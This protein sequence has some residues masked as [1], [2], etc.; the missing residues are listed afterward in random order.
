[1][2]FSCSRKYGIISRID[3]TIVIPPADK[4]NATVVMDRSLYKKKM[5]ILLDENTYWK[6]KTKRDPNHVH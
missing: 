2:H 1:M 4:G 6:L 3:S 5:E